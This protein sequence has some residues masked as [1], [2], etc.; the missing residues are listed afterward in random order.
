M[1]KRVSLDG[2]KIQLI[3]SLAGQEHVDYLQ[4]EFDYSNY[5]YYTNHDVFQASPFDF[6]S[7]K[8]PAFDQQ[9]EIK[10][11]K[12]KL[13]SINV[14]VLKEEDTNA[15]YTSNLSKFTRDGFFKA[16]FNQ[17]DDTPPL[18]QSLYKP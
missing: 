12:S 7:R 10:D 8:M 18:C 6:V 16:E 15:G 4:K 1:D 3:A 9:R 5:L 2:S 17:T 14:E 13:Y 11:K